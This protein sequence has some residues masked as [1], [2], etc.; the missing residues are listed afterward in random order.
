M[1]EIKKNFLIPEINLSLD[2]QI[3]FENDFN[4]EDFNINGIEEQSRVIKPKY[5]KGVEEKH[6]KYKY[7]KD[8]VEEIKIEEGFRAFCVI[9]GGFYFGDFI[10]AL[11]YEKNLLVKKMTISTLS[12]NQNNVDSFESLLSL[13]YVEKLDLIISAYFFSHE[14][15]N[16]I[17]YM[18]DKL[19]KENKFQLAIARTH[20][21][22]CTFELE[23][24]QKWIIHGSSNLR[25]SGNIEQFMIEENETLYNFNVEISDNI[26]EEYKT[27]KKEIGGVRL[28]QQVEGK[29]KKATDYQKKQQQEEGTEI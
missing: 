3:D 16:L 18:Y 4:I 7:A 24:G 27:I 22:I 17:P 10:E 1:F 14:R 19:D 20:C 2:L 9:N 11:I 15:K 6:L 23:N 29:V 28:W 5:K 8:L 21:K 26:V 12:M 25:S 13:G